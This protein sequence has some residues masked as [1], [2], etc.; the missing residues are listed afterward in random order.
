[1]FALM[2]VISCYATQVLL[3]SN[4]LLK[5]KN[6]N[7]SFRREDDDQIRGPDAEKALLVPPEFGDILLITTRQQLAGVIAHMR[8]LTGD[9]DAVALDTEGGNG[10]RFETLQIATTN[11]KAFFLDMRECDH[12]ADLLAQLGQEL[13]RVR[14]QQFFG[15]NYR[16]FKLFE[17]VTNSTAICCF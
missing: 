15:K 3:L 8:N 10:T 9:Y 5:F 14:N 6:Y 4:V 13:A 11:N 1:M 17:A 16:R 7:V 2:S 12:H